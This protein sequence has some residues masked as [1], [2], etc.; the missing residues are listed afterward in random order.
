MSNVKF[1]ILEY[2]MAIREKAASRKKKRRRPCT[3]GAHTALQ[4]RQIRNLSYRWHIRRPW[5]RIESDPCEGNPSCSPRIRAFVTVYWSEVVDPSR[6]VRE[7]NQID[8]YQPEPASHRPL[9]ACLAG[10]LDCRA[11]RIA[12]NQSSSP[13]R[14][15]R[16]GR[17]YV[18]TASSRQSYSPT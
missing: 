7:V 5:V 18:K 6:L 3:D 8:G 10:E 17:N 14:R 2:T 9:P 11:E 16:R 4:S 1:Q 13:P 15:A 12:A